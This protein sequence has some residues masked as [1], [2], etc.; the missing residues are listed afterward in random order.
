M[1]YLLLDYIQNEL[2]GFELHKVMLL[3]GIRWHATDIPCDT[4][5]ALQ[6]AKSAKLF[7]DYGPSPRVESL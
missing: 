4:H 6:R 3:W 7:V 2:E 1:L 5:A